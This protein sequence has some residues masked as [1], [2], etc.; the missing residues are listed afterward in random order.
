MILHYWSAGVGICLILKYG[1]ILETFRQI[2]SQV[3][4]PLAKLYKCC[5]CMGFWVGLLL[6]PFLYMVEGYG[7][8]SILLPF[9]ISFLGFLFDSIITVIHTINNY[10]SSESESDSSP[11]SSS[12]N[13]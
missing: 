4:P 9:S 3:F 5:L 10:F 2:T 12:P 11:N 8:E 1:S 7:I 6:V 13:K